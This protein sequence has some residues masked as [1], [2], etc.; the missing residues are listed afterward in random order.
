MIYKR[1]QLEA[2]EMETLAPYA[3]K[4]VESRGRLHS[5]PESKTRTA[6]QR[7]RDRIIHTT[8]FR[9]L[10]YKTLV[11]VF[12]EGDHYRTRLT[13]TLEVAQLGRSLARGLGANSN[14]TEAICLAHDLGHSPFG[15]AGEHILN[16]LMAEHG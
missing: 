3:L 10:E 4:S 12:Y 8:A 1:E 5:E 16:K 9:R 2:R 6:F 14:L 7:D 15:H 11:F 13:H